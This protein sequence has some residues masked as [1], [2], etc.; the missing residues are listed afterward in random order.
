MAPWFEA[1]WYDP[2]DLPAQHMTM[3]MPAQGA[4]IEPV[5]L[6][7]PGHD[8]RGNVGASRAD[9]LR[10]SRRQHRRRGSAAA[11]R[12]RAAARRAAVAS[13]SARASGA[14]S[15]SSEP[16]GNYVRSSRRAIERGDTGTEAV[17]ARDDHA[18]ANPRDA[19]ARVRYAVDDDEAVEADAHAAVD[20]ARRSRPGV[21]R[22][23]R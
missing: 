13:T 16:D 22:I 12:R 14:T 21:V 11:R 6:D 18:V 19:R 4:A 20:A 1:P 15:T 17:L 7:P 9:G 3:P 8:C 23:A 10:H 5:V 2:G